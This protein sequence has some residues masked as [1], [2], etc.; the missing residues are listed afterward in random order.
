MAYETWGRPDES[1]SNAVL[2]CHALTGDSHVAG[3][4]RL[5]A[6]AGWW[7]L[8]GPERIDTDRYFVVCAQ[9][10]RRLPGHDRAVVA[11]ARRAGVGEPV[12]PH[13]GTGPGR[14]RAAR[15][16]TRWASSGGPL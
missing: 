16:P 7:A 6:D 4:R 8:I 9:R 10:A 12:P 2:I 14:R 1:F 3:D 11:G 13:D 15:S 5:V